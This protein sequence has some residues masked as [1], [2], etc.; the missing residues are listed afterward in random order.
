[1]IQESMNT[2]S[3]RGPILAAI[4]IAAGAFPAWAH[5]SHGNYKNAGVHPA[6]GNGQGDALVDAA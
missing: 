5:H 2:M 1:M 6:D 3:R 4:V